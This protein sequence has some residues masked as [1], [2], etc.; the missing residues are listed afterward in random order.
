[1][2][3]NSQRNAARLAGAALGVGL[4][5]ALLLAS[6]PGAVS[7]PLPATVRVDVAPVGELEVD[8]SPTRPVLLAD[9]LRP[10]G[11][12]AA[13][14]FQ[15]RNQT[16]DDLTIDLKATADSTAL[17]GLLRLK[18]GTPG[19]LL[20]DSTLEGVRRRSPRLPLASGQRV[21]LR[22]EV[23]L[24]KDVL[25]GYEGRSVEVSLVPEVRTLGGPG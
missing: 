19:R 7:S 18:L 6:R 10:G 11:R 22:L 12:G 20:A 16:G 9:A 23:W 15:V 1:M 13:G 5:V 3:A 24:P 25:N 4:A 2:D 21:R 8:P 17:D 14:S